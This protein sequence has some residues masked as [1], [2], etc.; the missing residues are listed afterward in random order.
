VSVDVIKPTINH[1][2]LCK[3]YARVWVSTFWKIQVLC[4]E[5]NALL[6]NNRVHLFLCSHF[7]RANNMISNYYRI[8]SHYLDPFQLLLNFNRAVFELSNY[9]CTSIES[10][11]NYYCIIIYWFLTR[12]REKVKKKYKKKR[13]NVLISYFLNC[14][15]SFWCSITS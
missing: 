9:Y 15:S 3:R 10:L 1:V 13:I 5:D 7:Y 12:K 11:F 2:I 4:H 8:L 6:T 14:H